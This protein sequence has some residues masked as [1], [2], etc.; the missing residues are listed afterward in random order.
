LVRSRLATGCCHAILICV[1]SDS[2][3]VIRPP[4]IPSVDPTGGHKSSTELA[5][6]PALHEDCWRHHGRTRREESI[7][8]SEETLS[9]SRK[10][11]NPQ[12]ARSPDG[13][14]A[15]GRLEADPHLNPVG[16]GKTLP[17]Q[18]RMANNISRDEPPLAASPSALPPEKCSLLDLVGEDPAAPAQKKG[19]VSW[20]V[21]A[22]AVVGLLGAQT[23]RK[24][25]ARVTAT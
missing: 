25:L 17:A 5:E 19:K 14:A 15:C 9:P 23:K 20:S 11:V 6:V 16:V 18:K 4:G 3:R 13:G 7:A 1:C 12:R 8:S 10:R 21:A 24:S 22:G 2:S